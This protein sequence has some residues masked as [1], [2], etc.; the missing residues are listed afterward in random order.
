M[1]QLNDKIMHGASIN[2]HS[3]ELCRKTVHLNYAF[4]YVDS[5]LF[6]FAHLA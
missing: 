6:I 5:S 4:N 1:P 3:L 2:K